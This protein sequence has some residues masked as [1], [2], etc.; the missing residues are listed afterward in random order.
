[1][2]CFGDGVCEFDGGGWGCVVRLKGGRFCVR[3]GRGMKWMGSIVKGF[4]LVVHRF[5]D[6]DCPFPLL[7]V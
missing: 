6:I 1:M 3:L 2:G 5:S 4:G 7:D